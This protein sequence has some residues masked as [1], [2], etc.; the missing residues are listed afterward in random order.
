MLHR[1]YRVALA[2]LV[3]VVAALASVA[4]ANSSG[5]VT[6]KGIE[7]GVLG[8]T[9][10]IT[11]VNRDAARLTVTDRAGRKSSI[12]VYGGDIRLGLWSAGVAPNSPNP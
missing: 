10:K 6:V 11:K 9:L 8:K 7:P 1:N 12:V 3:I 5:K 4:Y 2:V